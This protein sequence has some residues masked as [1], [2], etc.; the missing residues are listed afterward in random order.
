[1]EGNYRVYSLLDSINRKNGPHDFGR[2]CQILLGITFKEMNFNI[3]IF[4]LSGRPDL[5]IVRR[6]IGFCVEVKAPTC[7]EVTIK[8]EDIDGVCNQHYQPIIC[9]N[10]YPEVK[11][12]W[13]FLDATKL[14]SGTF[15]SSSLKVYSIKE[16]EEEINTTFPGILEKYY[17]N[18]LNGVDCLRRAFDEM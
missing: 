7:T 9:I 18:S 2:L 11:P 6:D 3:S 1:M 10:T 16:M 12:K 4:Q 13:I 8:K 5:I 17:E 15:R 14:K